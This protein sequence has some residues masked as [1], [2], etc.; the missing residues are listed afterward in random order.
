MVAIIRNVPLEPHKRPFALIR[1]IGSIGDDIRYHKQADMLFVGGDRV[2]GPQ[3]TPMLWRHII[4][5]T[6]DEHFEGHTPYHQLP[7]KAYLLAWGVVPDQFDAP[8]RKLCLTFTWV[9]R[10]P[11]LAA[12]A[13]VRLVV[14]PTA[15]DYFSLGE[16]PQNWGSPESFF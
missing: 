4:A 11:Y 3:N 10:A 12:A 13:M 6:E 8:A 15:A 5:G 16:N 1:S 14:A 7:Q 9:S 2:Y